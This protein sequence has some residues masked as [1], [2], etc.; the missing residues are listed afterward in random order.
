MCR[1]P[2]ALLFYNKLA[3]KVTKTEVT[4]RHFCMGRHECYHLSSCFWPVIWSIVFVKKTKLKP[5]L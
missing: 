4:V 1:S 3:V 5:L 2:I